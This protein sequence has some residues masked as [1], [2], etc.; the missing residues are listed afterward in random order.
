MTKLIDWEKIRESDKSVFDKMFDYHYQP[1]CS[2]VYHYIE[3]KQVVEDIVIDCFSKIWEERLSLNIKSSLQNYLITIVK[4][5]AITY[6]RHNQLQ[7][8]NFDTIINSIP[9]EVTD[10][11][12][13]PEILNK[14]YH[15]INKLPEQRRKILK[16][17][18]FEEKSYAEIAEELNISINTVK[19]QMSRSYKFLKVELGVTHKTIHFLLFM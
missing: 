13:E 2:F 6:L 16:M 11:L 8:T 3:D 19:T 17:A 12:Y 18:A 4:N 5:S 1:L 15:A 9:D 7:F 14:L 10:P